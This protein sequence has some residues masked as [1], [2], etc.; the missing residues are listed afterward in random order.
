MGSYSCKMA[1]G[2]PLE[3]LEALTRLLVGLPL[4]M[5]LPRM[6]VLALLRGLGVLT[7]VRLWRLPA[8]SRRL[9][10]FSGPLH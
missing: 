10:A 1:L 8:R 7:R 3:P 2:H 6:T 9:V 4:R 5:A